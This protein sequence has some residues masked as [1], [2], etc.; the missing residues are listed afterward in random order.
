MRPSPSRLLALPC[1]NHMA[2]TWGW[3]WGA[4][5]YLW[6][7]VSKQKGTSVP[8]QQETESPQ[9]ELGRGPWA[10]D[11]TTALAT[12]GCRHGETLSREPSKPVHRLLTH[13][14]S[15][16]IQSSYF[17]LL[18]VW[19]SVSL[20]QGTDTRAETSNSERQGREAGSQS[21]TEQGLKP[22]ARAAKC[23]KKWARSDCAQRA[24][25]SQTL[26]REEV[27]SGKAE[28]PLSR[29]STKKGE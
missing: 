22:H 13:R 10:P 11:G 12:P 27:R 6:S 15:K 23:S 24:W 29:N 8:W 5:S 20:Q 18:S 7:T 17:M 26:G 4:E 2:W 25:E 1:Y 16:Q 19:W 3:P 28:T 21:L 14:N 9:N